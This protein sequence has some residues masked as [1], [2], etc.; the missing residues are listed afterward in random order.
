MGAVD[1]QDLAGPAVSRADRGLPLV[2]FQI[3]PC[4]V[5]RGRQVVQH[6]GGQMAIGHLL[7]RAHGHR[8]VRVHVLDAE[9]RAL[10]G[11]VPEFSARGAVAADAVELEQ[12]A[13]DLLV[14]GHGLLQRREPFAYFRHAHAHHHCI[15]LLVLD[16]RQDPEQV[17]DQRLVMSHGY[18][19]RLTR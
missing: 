13:P 6:D 16:I 2:G 11:A 15:G 4:A 5:E 8:H 19:C 17:V 14:A 10:D 18:Y 12:R 1:A 7:E 9:I 3:A